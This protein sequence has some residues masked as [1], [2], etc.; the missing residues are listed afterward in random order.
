MSRSAPLVCRHCQASHRLV[1]S[2][3][4]LSVGMRG[5]QL[6]YIEDV[7]RVI[8]RPR[9]LNVSHRTSSMNLFFLERKGAECFLILLQRGHAPPHRRGSHP[10]N[11]PGRHQQ[12]RLVGL[13]RF[14][15]LARLRPPANRPLDSRFCASQ[16]PWPS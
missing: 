11:I 12:L 7:F 16:Y 14:G 9:Y 2:V 13:Q 15:R 5:D 1:E 6:A 3:R 10:G 4:R 8:S